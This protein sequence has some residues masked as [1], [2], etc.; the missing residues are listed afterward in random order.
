[1]IEP[2]FEN[3]KQEITNRVNNAQK[4]I[5]ICMAWFSDNDILDSLINRL[6][7]GVAIEIILLETPGNKQ[8]TKTHPGVNQLKKFKLNLNKFK[9]KG[10]QITL[11]NES[12]D[13]FLHSKFCVIDDCITITGSYNWTYKAI[14]NIENIVIIEDPLIAEKYLKEFEKIK[15]EKLEL[16]TIRSFSPCTQC[17]GIQFRMRVYDLDSSTSEYYK[18][19]KDLQLCTNELS[20][21]IEIVNDSEDFLCDF[22]ELFRYTYEELQDRQESEEVNKEALRINNEENLAAQV[23]SR[24]DLFSI[25]IGDDIMVLAVIAND[26]QPDNTEE[27]K[28]KI[29]WTHDLFKPYHD[30]II[31]ASENIIEKIKD[32]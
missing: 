24:R 14:S 5:N 31:E 2:F 19:F 13:F 28:L 18:N 6:E 30:K 16:V 7:K 22:N 3:I 8:K 27:L 20:N 9:R 32:F 29:W 17:S 25:N 23:G 21:H 1:M 12:N 26:L 10:G 15:K 11:I 4:T